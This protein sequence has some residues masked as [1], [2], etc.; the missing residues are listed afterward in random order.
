[1]SGLT[2]T[3]DASAFARAAGLLER[4]SVRTER[5]LRLLTQRAASR[6]T[7]ALARATPVGKR[8]PEDPDAGRPHMR[9][10]W[11]QQTTGA[12]DSAVFNEAPYALFQFSGTQSHWVAPVQAA[13]L[14]WFEGGHPVFSRGHEV[15]GMA[16][17]PRLLR[18]LDDQMLKTEGDLFAYGIRE[19]ERLAREIR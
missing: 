13:A 19:T 4:E 9:E 7:K 3:I 14:R 8:Q 6:A 15:S 11:H 5:D 2:L 18:A 10:M 1:M 16:P 12:M 17:N